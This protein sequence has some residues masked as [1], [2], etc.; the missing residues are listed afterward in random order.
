MESAWCAQVYHQTN[1]M[2]L[3]AGIAFHT[4]VQLGGLYFAISVVPKCAAFVV[5]V[6]SM[7][8]PFVCVERAL[9]RWWSVLSA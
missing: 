8:T 3:V 7:P 2:A 6:A 5:G 1:M 9:A 4:S